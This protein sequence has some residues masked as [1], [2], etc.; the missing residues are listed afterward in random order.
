[1]KN[2]RWDKLLGSFLQEMG[3]IKM[4]QKMIK[5]STLGIGEW[6][7]NYTCPI[8]NEFTSYDE[9]AKPQVACINCGV[10]NE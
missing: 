1:M 6:D 10:E 4:E 7:D 5:D 8:C 2:N 3:K 9:W